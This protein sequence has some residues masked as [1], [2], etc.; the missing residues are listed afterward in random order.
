MSATPHAVELTGVLARA[1]SS[2]L[3]RDIVALDVSRSLAIA[4]IFLI[5]TAGNERQAG[6]IVDVIDEAAGLSG[7]R[8]LRREGEAEAKWIL[9]DLADVVV[10]VMSVE[11]RELYALE[12]IWKD[13]PR[14]D[15]DLEDEPKQV[16]V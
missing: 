14:L 15:L 1:A 9:L 8:V 7:E 3:G 5:V 4:D 13:A 12:R 11:D 16:A 10:H 2:K 6:A